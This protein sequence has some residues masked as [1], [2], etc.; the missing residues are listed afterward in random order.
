MEGG[1]LPGTAGNLARHLSQPCEDQGDEL[2][3]Y[4]ICHI[5]H[6]VP[7]LSEKLSFTGR[8][9]PKRKWKGI[10]QQREAGHGR[11]SGSGC[12]L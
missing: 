7:C 8:G 11:K 6:P 12:D 9:L 3:R 4:G 5:K 1:T 10:L 2:W